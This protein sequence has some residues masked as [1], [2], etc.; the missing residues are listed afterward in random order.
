MDSDDDCW[1]EPMNDA[2]D[3]KCLFCDGSFQST[4]ELWEHCNV[5]H[6]FDIAHVKQKFGLDFYGYVKMINFVRTEKPNPKSLFEHTSPFPW[7]DDRYLQPVVVDD[8]LLQYDIEDFDSDEEEVDEKYLQNGSLDHNNEVTNNRLQIA[9]ERASM[10]ESA[11]QQALADLEAMRAGV[12]ELV[13]GNEQQN[14]LDEAAR[15][16]VVLDDEEDP[17]FS[18]YSH[19]SIHEEML[20]DKV[21]TLSYKNF[22]HKNRHLFE[23]KVVLDVGCGSGILSIF[24]AQS[25]AR[26]V[27]GIDKS[28]IVYHAMDIV[29]ENK[30]DNIVTLRRGKVED[31]NLDVEKVDIIISEW[32]GYFLLFESMLDTVLFARDKWMAPDGKV[33][34]DICTMSIVGVEDKKRMEDKITFWED[35]YGVKMSCMKNLVLSEPVVDIV[36]PNTIVTSNCVLKEINVNKVTTESL[37]FKSDFQL[38][39]LRDGNLNI[40]VGYFDIMFEENCTEKISFSTHPTS[41]PTHWKQT[42]FYLESPLALRKDELIDGTLQCRKN[43]KDPRSLDIVLEIR[44]NI[45]KQLMINKYTLQ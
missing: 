20:K 5:N 42:L 41:P 36:D 21:R 11:L 27:F 9:L 13:L 43:R 16:K 15:S 30:L 38:Q 4:S 7:E 39:A 37:D 40:I 6:Q 45:S 24:A 3:V 10:A 25:G 31:I 32:M 8:P 1:E 28:S 33:Y 29:R 34:P 17:Y 23:G 35:V 2:Q 44:D 18:S 22:T 26:K 12:H 14:R 19:Y